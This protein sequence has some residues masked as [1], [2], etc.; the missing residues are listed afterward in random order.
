MSAE[1]M[2]IRKGIT[3]PDEACKKT[4]LFIDSEMESVKPFPCKHDASLIF[5]R[6]K[7]H[8]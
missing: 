2:K 3:S 1:E 6:R 7:G 8:L 5:P 4:F